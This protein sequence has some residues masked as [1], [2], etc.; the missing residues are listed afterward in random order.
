MRGRLGEGAVDFKRYFWMAKTLGLQGPISMHFEYPVLT[1][2][3]ERLPKPARME[4]TVA[5]M[6]KD[7]STLRRM[8]ASQGL[9]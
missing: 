7:V 4:R 1:A 8:L 6:R 2:G 3:E 9:S 5:V